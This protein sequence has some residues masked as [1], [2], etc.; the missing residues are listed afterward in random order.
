[1]ALF[2]LLVTPPTPLST[3]EMYRRYDERAAGRGR[4]VGGAGE[5]KEVRGG[6][7]REPVEPGEFLR[8]RREGPHR[9][10]ASLHNDLEAAAMDL[11]PAVG[12]VKEALLGAGALGAVM[13]GSGPTVIGVVSDEDHGRR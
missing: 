1:G 5:G 2:L 4:D 13:S 10:A 6:G 7:R 11:S 3:P 12:A 8:A 9:L